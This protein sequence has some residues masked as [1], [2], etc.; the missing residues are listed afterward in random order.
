MKWFTAYA[1]AALAMLLFDGLW[2]SI[3]AKRFYRPAL[4]DLLIDG[5]RPVPA[6]IFYLL[7]VAGIVVLAACPGLAVGKWSA[8]LWRGAVLGLVA[9]GTYDLTNQAT[10]R[11]WPIY[12]TALDMA[13]G[14]FLTGFASTAGYFAARSLVGA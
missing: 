12:L 6:V 9:Y 1:G 2:L 5:F 3:A 4:G 8:A 14:T 10:L 7:Y 13:W 11:H